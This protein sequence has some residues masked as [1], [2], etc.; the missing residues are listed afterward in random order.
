M[1]ASIHSEVRFFTEEKSN[2]G[3]QG[4]EK[5]FGWIVCLEIL[6]LIYMSLLRS[7]QKTTL[8]LALKL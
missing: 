2:P 4:N 1:K 5:Q 6:E 8:P 3:E 7:R